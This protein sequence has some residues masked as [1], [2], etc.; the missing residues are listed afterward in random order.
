MHVQLGYLSK[1]TYLIFVL[2]ST[3]EYFTYMHYGRW[4]PGQPKGN[5]RLHYLQAAASAPREGLVSIDK[6]KATFIKY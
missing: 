1:F 3:L 2:C 5:A 6:C 4:K